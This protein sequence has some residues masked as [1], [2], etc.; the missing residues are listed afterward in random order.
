MRNLILF[1]FF[2]ATIFSCKDKGATN[3]TTIDTTYSSNVND[4]YKGMLVYVTTDSN[5]NVDRDTCLNAELKLTFLGTDSAIEVHLKDLEM[6]V[7]F[8]AVASIVG[9]FLTNN[10]DMYS[11]LNNSSN[12][13]IS[14]ELPRA[15][16][17]VYYRY[18]QMSGL[19]T[20]YYFYG[21]K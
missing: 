12:A 18:T 8:S 20:N 7:S 6:N 16:D 14:V 2:S 13:G 1:C 17:S 15:N 19:G 10:R 9:Q 4:P 5:S 3:V 21:K 11:C